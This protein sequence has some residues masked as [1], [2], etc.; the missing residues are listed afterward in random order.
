[1]GTLQDLNEFDFDM[2]LK[3]NLNRHLSMLPQHNFKPNNNFKLNTNF[4][5][6]SNFKS[7][8]GFKSD[9][10]FKPATNSKPDNLAEGVKK[11]VVDKIG[12]AVAEKV[13][14][15]I[16]Q[17]YMGRDIN[18]TNVESQIQNMKNNLSG[19]S[20]EYQQRYNGNM[21]DPSQ[22][23][24]P[25][26][27]G[28]PRKLSEI[29]DSARTPEQR[30]LADYSPEYQNRYPEESVMALQNQRLLDTKVVNPSSLQIDRTPLAMYPQQ[31]PSGYSN[32][33]VATNE[34]KNNQSEKVVFDDNLSA[35]EIQA[36]KDAQAGESPDGFSI[37]NQP[38]QY[39]YDRTLYGLQGNSR[40]SEYTD[41]PTSLQNGRKPVSRQL[42]LLSQQDIPELARITMIRGG[43]VTQRLVHPSGADDP[44]KKI[45]SR[46]SP[47]ELSS[48]DR[49]KVPGLIDT[50]S[51]LVKDMRYQYPDGSVSGGFY[52]PISRGTYQTQR[53]AILGLTE[54]RI[55]ANMDHARAMDKQQMVN[56]GALEKQQSINQ[57]KLAERQE[58]AN[59]IALDRKQSDKKD[60]NKYI[61]DAIA[62]DT[63]N[64]LFYD[65]SSE[66]YDSEIAKRRKKHA[67]DWD[68]EGNDDFIDTRYKGN[69]VRID[70][71]N[72]AIYLNG[73]II[74]R[75]SK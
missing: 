23:Y 41:D 67:F 65:V 73:E 27:Q 17:R 45:L 24:S 58:E 66:N 62:Q 59:K 32:N 70:K 44:Y 11:S 4:K 42:P 29:T 34:I 22:A 16:A 33:I 9:N 7:E 14:E 74:G 47:E 1:M 39:N 49:T 61:N 30:S 48:F 71:R 55:D 20:P 8:F 18:G 52:D 35:R 40:N 57:N 15:K 51:K 72:G 56:Q 68:T 28:V 63:E 31:A 25:I 2:G 46:F 37:V 6:T 36:I 19:Y 13:G 69:A 64:G 10:N 5:P 75:R 3:N 12:K 21:T 50:A 53:G 26:L 54:D 43:D 60:R 38:Q